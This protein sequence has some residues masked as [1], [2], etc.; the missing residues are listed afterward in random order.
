M[1]P[2]QTSGIWPTVAR[3][4]PAGIE[5]L[6]TGVVDAGRGQLSVHDLGALAHS[7]GR[8]LLATG[9]CGS[10]FM[11]AITYIGSGPN[12]VVKAIAEQHHVRMPSLF[13]CLVCSVGT[14][15]PALIAASAL[16]S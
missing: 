7:A 1:G 3:E 9:S 16:V 12:F 4:L 15:V 10:I 2:G 11:G 14:L 6:A 5:W 13:G 8:D